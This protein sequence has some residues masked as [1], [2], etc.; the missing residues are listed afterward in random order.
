MADK[1]RV[2]APKQR[3]TTSRDDPQRTKLLMI[4][5]GALALLALGVVFFVT[6]GRGGAGVD[7]ASVRA[8][9]E[10]AG[11]TLEAKI[12]APPASNGYHTVAVPDGT[13]ADWNTD[14]PVAGAHYGEAAI[15]GVYSDQ[16][17][18]ARVV[19]NLE[20]GGIFIQYGADVRERTLAELESF[21]NDRKT[22]TLM[23]PLPSLGD[24]IALGAWVVRD[25]EFER[26]G[27]VLG[28]GYLAK[29]KTF[30]EE[31]FASFF[32]AFQFKGPERFDP[33]NLLPGN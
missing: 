25:D 29:C 6:V 23:A 13:S 32:D 16:L 24:E 12:P 7:E 14:P 27:S 22:G 18:Q 21:Y 19:H 26:E 5:G 9:L 3:A 30:D 1:P 31:A 2:K 4:G 17:E 28:T 8:D 10:A 20:H 15:F 11:C 33:A